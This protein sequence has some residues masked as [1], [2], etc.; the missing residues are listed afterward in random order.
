MS[1][2]SRRPGVAYVQTDTMDHAVHLVQTGADQDIINSKAICGVK[3]P[4]TGWTQW[5]VTPPEA[6]VCHRC[7]RIYGRNWG[8]DK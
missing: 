7:K 6:D 5:K 3:P 4:V 1:Q 8:G 2:A